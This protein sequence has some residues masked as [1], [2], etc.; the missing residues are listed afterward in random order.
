ML[1]L[2]ANLVCRNSFALRTSRGRKIEA[3]SASNHHGTLSLNLKPIL[4]AKNLVGEDFCEK[5]VLVVHFGVFS[6]D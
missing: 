5:K 1:S 4:D 6:T 2:F 3:S